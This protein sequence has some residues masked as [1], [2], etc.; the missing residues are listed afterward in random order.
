MKNFLFFAQK[1]M[2]RSKSDTG[3]IIPII[4]LLG[5][6]LVTLYASSAHYAQ[7][8]FSDDFHFL[9][10]QLMVI[11]MSFIVCLLC[12]WINMDF[13]RKILPIIVIGIFILCLCTFLPGMGVE[14][15]GSSRWIGLPF[16]MT[17]QPSEAAKI[18]V[19]LFLANL[20]DKKYDRLND[21]A[22][23]VLPATIGVFCFVLIVFLQ[24]D[25][26]TALFILMIGCIIFFVVGIKLYWFAIFGVFAVPVTILFVFT[27][28]YRV[29]RL[30]GFLRPEYDI[31]GI[32]YQVAM[33]KKAINNGGFLGKGMSGLETVHS[34]PEIQA[35]FVFAGWAEGMGFIGVLIY[36]LILGVF[37][38][39]TF[40]MAFRCPDRF[41]SITAF[42]CTLIIVL[43][44]LINCG[45]VAGAFPATGIPLPFFSAGG[46]SILTVFCL[47]G[48]LINISRY[49]AE[50]EVEGFVL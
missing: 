8:M 38:W 10:R 43:Q 15:N 4:L 5:L 42:G 48:F 17:F 19:V 26:S 22:T 46:S 16:G 28:Q 49:K 13:L 36:M 3:F 11:G 37:A 29:D 20:F 24:N 21:A 31:N 35:D 14:R 32:N 27:K 30:I 33:S 18:A 23:C 34:I 44:S 25:F 41:R 47:C 40:G 2:P 39:K 1:P 6:G 9:E 50:D 12:S 45:V 7:R